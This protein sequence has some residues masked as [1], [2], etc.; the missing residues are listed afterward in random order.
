MPTADTFTAL[1]RGN[2]FASF[3]TIP[4]SVATDSPA[5][6]LWELCPEEFTLEEVMNWAWNGHDYTDTSLD[7]FWDRQGTPENPRENYEIKY[8]LNYSEANEEWLQNAAYNPSG[9]DLPDNGQGL[10]LIAMENGAVIYGSGRNTQPY[11]RVCSARPDLLFQE[12]RCSS[13]GKIF[14]RASRFIRLRIV[15]DSANDN[16]RFLAFSTGEFMATEKYAEEHG[17]VNDTTTIEIPITSTKN[18]SIPLATWTY[19]DKSFELTNSVVGEID[20]YTY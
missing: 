5:W 13:D 9:D 19:T 1:G 8:F 12:F 17:T 15:Y 14:F 2:G 7:I 4:I 10:R 18:I 16:Y 20:F 11:E 3:C 6:E